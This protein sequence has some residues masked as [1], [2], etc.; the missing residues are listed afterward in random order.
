MELLTFAGGAL[1]TLQRRIPSRSQVPTST[2]SS[3]SPD[4]ASGVEEG[5]GEETVS[6]P[7]S[8]WEK[9]GRVPVFLGRNLIILVAD[10]R[11]GLGE[12]GGGGGG[13][14]WGTGAAVAVD[15]T[16]AAAAA[17]LA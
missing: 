15:E 1:Y 16:V 12:G 8:S 13:G 5:G 6:S 3:P 2:I 4:D 17:F 14:G 10:G 9:D 7:P 11:V